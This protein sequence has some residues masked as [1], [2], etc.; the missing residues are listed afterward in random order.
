MDV[1][2]CRAGKRLQITEKR[3]REK[4]RGYEDWSYLLDK[5][6]TFLSCRDRKG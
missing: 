3:K 1:G 5:N 6:A 4:K 2:S